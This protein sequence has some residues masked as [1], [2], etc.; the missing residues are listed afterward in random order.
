MSTIKPL[1]RQTK[2]II[3]A[4]ADIQLDAPSDQDKAFL[5]RQLVQATLPHSDPGNVPVWSRQNGNVTLTIQQG[6]KRDGEPVGHPYG[7]IPRLLMYWMTTE[8]IRTK[9]SKLVL[10]DSLAMFMEE[11][12]LDS[13]G[14]GP[15]SD[16]VRLEEQMKRLFAARISFEG[17]LHQDGMEGEVTQYLPV[18]R[19]TVFWWNQKNPEQRALWESYVELDQDFFQAITANPVPVDLRAL[20]AIKRSPL[21]LDLYSLLTYQAFRAGKAG[22]PRF[23]TWRQLQGALGTSYADPADLKKAVKDALKKIEAVYPGLAIGGR[24]GGLEVLPESLPAIDP[25]T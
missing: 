14:K 17:I 5:A 2:K 24:E 12:G 19:R 13:R 16:R 10:G 4:S 6:Y 8:A 25:R 22:R 20:R 23:M 21:A 11:L 9:E 7:T 1:T 3:Q 18:A 15:R